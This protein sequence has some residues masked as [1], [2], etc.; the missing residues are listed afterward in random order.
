MNA[1]AEVEPRPTGTRTCCRNESRQTHKHLSLQLPG[2]LVEKPVEPC[3]RWKIVYPDQVGLLGD[4]AMQ[5]VV[6]LELEVK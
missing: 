1:S 5:S 4:L 2:A 6:A 3:P